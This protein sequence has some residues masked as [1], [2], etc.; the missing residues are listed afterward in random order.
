MF[1][2]K[3][4]PD[5]LPFLH[6]QLFT[7]EWK[8]EEYK[9]L[10]LHYVNGQKK[11]WYRRTER[12]Y[13]FRRWAIRKATGTYSNLSNFESP[14]I[15]VYLFRWYFA[16][17]KKVVISLQVNRLSTE[18]PALHTATPVPEVFSL[19]ANYAVEEPEILIKQASFSPSTLDI[20]APSINVHVEAIKN[21]PAIDW[22][23]SNW[24]EKGLITE[25]TLTYDRI[26]KLNNQPN[27]A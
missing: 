18:I 9:W 14:R 25:E 3:N 12:Q 11:S 4:H 7:L 22:P 16:W 26:E 19:A 10:L 8:S 13:R 1:R 20:S 6:D 21:T 15:V 17:P 24:M 2:F 5:G 27:H 23:I